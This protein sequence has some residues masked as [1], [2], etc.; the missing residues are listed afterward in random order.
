MAYADLN[1]G[2]G[3]F[4]GFFGTPEER[5][6]KREKKARYKRQMKEVGAM[7]RRDLKDLGHTRLE[8]KQSIYQEYMNG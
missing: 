8:L 3:F 1:L 2:N 5:Q 6:A 4:L 7:T